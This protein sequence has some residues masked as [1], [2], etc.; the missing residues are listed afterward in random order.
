M[1]SFSV[2]QVN[3]VSLYTRKLNVK[4]LGKLQGD[5]TARLGHGNKETTEFFETNDSSYLNNTGTIIL[6]NQSLIT[7]NFRILNAGKITIGDQTYIN[8]N[9]VM[10]IKHSLTIGHHCAIGWNCTFMDNDHHTVNGKEE[11]L[12]IH[13][14]NNVWMGAGSVILKGVSIGDNS[15]VAAGSVVT[16]SFGPRLLIGGVP[17]K[18]IKEN[19]NWE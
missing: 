14:G 2:K 18:I 15:I 7:R 16:K 3:G 1:T 19:V 4:S 11:A 9:G 5:G 12:A 8:P 6:G 17:A 13:I 10:R